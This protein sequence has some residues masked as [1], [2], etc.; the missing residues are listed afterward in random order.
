M[1]Y[2]ILRTEK[3]KVGDISKVYKHQLRLMNVPN[4]DPNM[5][6]KNEYD[7]R[8]TEDQYKQR[9][10]DIRQAYQ[11]KHGKKL[12]K[13]VV[14][15][16]EL[17]C[18]FSPEKWEELGDEERDSWLNSWKEQNVAW[19]EQTFGKENVAFVAMHRDEKTP[20]ITA[21]VM[22]VREGEFKVGHWLDGKQKC[23]QLQDSYAESME[24]LGLERGVKGSKAKHQRLRDFHK[25]VMVEPEEQLPA[26]EPQEPAEEYV[27]RIQPQLTVITDR[28]K[29]FA[30]VQKRLKEKE[31]ENKKMQ[32]EL[33]ATQKELEAK[34]TLQKLRDIPLTKVM[35]ALGYEKDKGKSDSRRSVYRTEQGKISIMDNKF[36]NFMQN[37][38]SNGAINLVMHV[39]GC[40]F[41]QA[42]AKLKAL[43]TEE[44]VK[45][46]VVMYTAKRAVEMTEKVKADMRPVKDYSKN[47][48]VREYL[49]KHRMLPAGLVDKLINR[50]ILFANV[51]SSCVFTCRN[52][53]GEVVGYEI[54]G[55]A[56]TF[57]QRL[58]SKDSGWFYI[59]DLLRADTVVL[60]E[61]AIDVLSYTAVNNVNLKTTCV[62]SLS[63]NAI[64]ER[65]IELI[66]N[67]KVVY[68]ADRDNNEIAKKAVEEQF[69]RL[70]Q[71]IPTATREAPAG[72]KDW[73]EM[74]TTAKN[75]QNKY[76]NFP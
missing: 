33:E 5:I 11:N 34:E 21:L 15:G 43:F 50:D 20:H 2:A 57:R 74:L 6:S 4:A 42:V 25:N 38:G 75:M 62:L 66:R 17:L 13:D 59:G 16:V 12:K 24:G 18:T 29:A 32:E 49:V 19:I 61:S 41:K 8:V 69:A 67:K 76:R 27:K 45:K 7:V 48:V 70:K 60:C 35:E 9:I 30:L 52:E 40:D 73:N 44:E 47:A 22:P 10:T 1:A 31:K 53:H 55:T 39:L 14:V 23:Q 28:A 71:Q 68:A 64:P 54:R 51:F 56:T 36:Y 72:Y 65:L 63:G 46:A 26:P 58:G 3:H 37:K